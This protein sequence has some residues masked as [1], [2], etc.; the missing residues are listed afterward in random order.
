VRIFDWCFEWI[1]AIGRAENGAA[2]MR[3]T[4]DCVAVERYH[5]ILAE[6]TAITAT[7]AINFPATPQR[8]EHRRANDGVETGRVAAARVDRNFHNFDS[9]SS[10]AGCRPVARFE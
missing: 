6:Q 7:D 8:S 5:N 1:A 4:A 2:L 3:D 10:Q 9:M